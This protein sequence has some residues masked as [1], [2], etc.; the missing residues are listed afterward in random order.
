MIYFSDGRK[1][2]LKMCFKKSNRKV[3]DLLNGECVVV[4]DG[5]FAYNT[6]VEW[7]LADF[8]DDKPPFVEVNFNERCEGDTMYFTSNLDESLY[9]FNELIFKVVDEEN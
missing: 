4:I 7:S 5:G 9:E 2:N 8:L 3:R 1:E 6:I